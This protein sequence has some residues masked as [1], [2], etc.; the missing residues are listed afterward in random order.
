MQLRAAFIVTVAA[1]VPLLAGCNDDGRTLRPARPDQVGSV[2]TLAPVTE[3]SVD[4]NGNIDGADGL[5][6]A[7][8][9]TV[10][11]QTAPGVTQPGTDTADVL[12]LYSSFDDGTAI[13]PDNTCSGA[14]LSPVLTWSKAPVGT[15][16][17]ALTMTDLDA[18]G[19]VHWAV[20]GIDPLDIGL[21]E[22]IVPA[23]A[24]QGL[25]G[26]GTPGY[27]GP[28]P[29]AGQT[30]TYRITVHYLDAQT[31]LPDGSPGADLLTSI[32][33]STLASATITGTYSQS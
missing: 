10:P 2:S 32:E 8:L 12:A 6:D 27:T 31:E 4:L 17:I 26:N 1:V 29:P 23:H 9:S 15:V 30:H 22:G 7:A 28:C 33:G 14:N 16:E 18:P 13:D 25:N 5:G 19:F 24:I 11:V 3:P 21:G 20:A